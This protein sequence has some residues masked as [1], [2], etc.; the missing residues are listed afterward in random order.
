LDIYPT[1][2]ELAGLDMPAH[3]EGVSLVPLI[4]NP[5]TEW[6]HAAITTSGFGNHAVST[7]QY[8]Y[9][10]Y[11]DNTEELYDLDSDPNEWHNLANDPKLGEKKQELVAL[12]PKHNEPI[13]PAASRNAE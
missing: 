8:R 13:D 12:L 10:R 9:I 11:A 3:I 1:L 5:A 2:V 4:E 6:N 7:D